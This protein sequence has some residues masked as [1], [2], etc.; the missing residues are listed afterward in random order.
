MG[1]FCGLVQS[2]SRWNPVGC[3]VLSLV[4]SM[5]VRDLLT[6]LCTTS[7]GESFTFGESKIFRS[8]D[9]FL[10]QRLGDGNL[11]EPAWTLVGRCTSS[12][13]LGKLEKARI[14]L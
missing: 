9:F 6:K 8:V 5:Q 1:L 3:S 13:M 14:W 10:L 7:T 12:S 11:G 2:K 4:A